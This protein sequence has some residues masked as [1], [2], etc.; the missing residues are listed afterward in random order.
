MQRQGGLYLPNPKATSHQ[1]GAPSG[2]ALSSGKGVAWPGSLPR[3]RPVPGRGSGHSPSG[4]VNSRKVGSETTVWEM[5]CTGASTQVTSLGRQD[6]MHRMVSVFS[7]RSLRGPQHKGG[8]KLGPPR[9]PETGVQAGGAGG[10]AGAPLPETAPSET[11]P[12]SRAQLLRGAASWPFLQ[13]GPNKH[14]P[15]APGSVCPGQDEQNFALGQRHKLSFRFSNGNQI[16]SF[17]CSTRVS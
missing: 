3:R 2:Q 11:R 1:G 14:P 12:A 15:R 6:L 13:T 5:V 10:G 9:P 4:R 8:A 16:R 17:A 7:W